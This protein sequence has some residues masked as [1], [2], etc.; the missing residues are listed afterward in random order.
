MKQ[1]VLPSVEEVWRER[2]KELVDAL[3]ETIDELHG[4]L[5]LDEQHRHG[6]D[7]DQLERALGPLAATSLDVGS[8]SRVLEGSTRSRAMAPERR[9][10]VEALIP[11]L[12]ELRKEWSNAPLDA[13]LVDIDRPDEEIRALAEAHFSRLARVFRAERIAQLE[14]RARY[15][16]QLHDA[17]FAEFTWRELGVEDPHHPGEAIEA[18]ARYLS[19]LMDKFSDLDLPDRVAM[20]IASYNVGPRHVFD[21]RR[22]A[23]EIGLDRDIPRPECDVPN[24]L[25]QLEFGALLAGGIHQGAGEGV[26]IRTPIVIAKYGAEV[27]CIQT[28]ELA[29]PVTRQL[30]EAR[31]GMQ[32]AKYGIE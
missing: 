24:G 1:Q 14:I 7:P 23:D 15:E 28:I 17:V 16:A 9:E 29:P 32:P 19:S 30:L 2:C 5:G 3:A 6:H 18:G 25:A 27:L 22:L 21:A 10:R 11:L 8:L 26:I 13:A 12:L 31:F 4:L 20:A